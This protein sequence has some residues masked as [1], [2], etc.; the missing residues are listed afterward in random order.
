M[1]E[2]ITDATVKVLPAPAN[3]NKVY[4]DAEVK[5]FGCRVTAAGGRS[6]V[7]N[8]RNASRRDRRFTIGSYPDWSTVA[9][10]AEAKELKKRIDRGEDPVAERKA[11]REAPTVADLCA[12]Y[13]TDHLPKKRP[14]SQKSDRQMI[15]RHI[16]PPLKHVQ[17]T[18]LTFS[19]IDS[20]H[21]RITAT[22]APIRANRVV[23]VLSKMLSLAI[24]WGWRTD[25]PAKGI[26]RNAEDKRHRYLTPP[27]LARLTVALAEHRDQQASNIIRLLLLTGA[28]RGELQAAR[29]ADIDLER[30]VWTKPG[31][32]TKQ[33]TQH[34]VPLSDAALKLLLNID[35]ADGGEYVFPGRDKGHRVEIK[36]SW[37]AI[38]KAA[39]ISGVRMHD[40]RHTYASVLASSGLSL[41]VIGA[42][43]GHTQPATTARYAHLLDDPLRAATERASAIITGKPSAEVVPMKRGG[44]A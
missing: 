8:Y 21:R 40:L 20:L 32:T 18:A 13:E 22:G 5:G 12:R 37:A 30:G 36:D 34:R 42:L 17:V 24:K 16:L 3:G 25:N 27:E 39:G 44:A 33:K 41:P 26:E 29:W 35:R 19:D 9:A 7:L 14:S 1:A 15:A 43:L 10:R 38:C 11:K 23:A 28:R 4:Y 31:A 6:F 2:K